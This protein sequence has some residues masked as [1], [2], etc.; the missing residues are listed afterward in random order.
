MPAR[1]ILLTLVAALF[2]TALAPAAGA[3][4]ADP[5]ATAAAKQKKTEEAQGGQVPQEPGADQGGQAHR[6]LPLAACGAARPA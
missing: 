4:P 5:M 3:S 6:R 2:V 1:L